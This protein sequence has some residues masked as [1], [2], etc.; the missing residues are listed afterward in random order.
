MKITINGVEITLKFNFGMLYILGS[1]WGCEGPFAVN[2]KFLEA[3][4]PFIE[5]FQKHSGT[6]DINTVDASGIE[7]PFAS[8]E[9]FTDIV[10]AAAKNQDKTVILDA[11]EVSQYL[12][13]NLEVFGQIVVH[14]L[15]AMPQPKPEDVGKPNPAQ[16]M[17]ETPA[18]L[19]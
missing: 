12:F 17:P 6:A 19:H 7:I 8:I 15:Q 5:L 9:V 1:M 3:A 13:D 10:A 14:F 11:G 2:K 18:A 16:T 4:S